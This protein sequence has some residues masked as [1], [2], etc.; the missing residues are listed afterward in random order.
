MATV[1]ETQTLLDELFNLSIHTH[2]ELRVWMKSSSEVI[3]LRGQQLALLRGLLD[4]AEAD[5]PNGL[6]YG[7]LE[8]MI[9]Q[10]DAQTRLLGEITKDVRA[11][12]VSGKMLAEQAL[13]FRVLAEEAGYDG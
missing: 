8:G 5:E 3:K 13:Q 7:K 12:R 6:V 2:A 4:E 10:I 11:L 1:P 9:Q